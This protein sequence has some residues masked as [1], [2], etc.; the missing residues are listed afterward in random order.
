[1]TDRDVGQLP[2]DKEP[3]PVPPCPFDEDYSPQDAADAAMMEEWA[4]ESARRE[5]EDDWKFYRS[6]GPY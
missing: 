2:D 6:G 1:M 5:R 4:E 3:K